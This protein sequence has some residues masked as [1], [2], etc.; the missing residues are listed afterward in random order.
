MNEQQPTI[1]RE[2]TRAELVFDRF[3]RGMTHG[4]AWLTI[5]LVFLI[6]WQVGTA[7]EPAVRQ[8]GWSFLTGKTWDASKGQLGVLPEIVGT[9]Y[10][11][12][13]GVAL[14]S[15][16][17]IAIAI[18][19]TEQYLPPKWEVLLKNLID[20]L[21]AVP[22]VVYGLW[23]IFVVIPFIRPA[24][25][26]VHDHL[27]WISVFNTRLSGPGVLP[28]AL[29]LGI[30]VLP[31]VT[32]ISRDAIAAVPP[33]NNLGWSVFAP[34]DTLA[35]LLANKFPEASAL[36]RQALMYAAL[37]LLAI[38]LAVNVLGTLVTSPPWAVREKHR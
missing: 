23:G 13:L 36:E 16:F 6:V 4:F 7:A 9:L 2:P 10:T 17:G 27:G 38:T 21:A 37:V 19:L 32:A 28:A 15:L 20:L 11:S 18:F 26:W 31:T 22:S 33:A 29:V 35:A 30:M 24:G 5:L 1:A 25:N 12:V 14:G 34:S 8:F 3:F